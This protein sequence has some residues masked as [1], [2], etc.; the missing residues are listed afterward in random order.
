MLQG[1]TEIANN[2]DD[3]LLEGVNEAGHQSSSSEIDPEHC[4]QVRIFDGNLCQTK[5]EALRNFM[6]TISTQSQFDT[7]NKQYRST[8]AGESV[9][10]DPLHMSS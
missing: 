8:Q 4:I 6:K 2:K 9:G 10:Q 5:E 1:S 7:L 3:S